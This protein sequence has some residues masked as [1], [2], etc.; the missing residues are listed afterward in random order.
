MTTTDELTQPLSAPITLDPNSLDPNSLDPNG[1]GITKTETIE[2][3]RMS[4][5]TANARWWRPLLVAVVALGIYAAMFFMMFIAM[6]VVGI[7]SPRLEAAI[8]AFLDSGNLDD[9]T[10]PV[11]FVILLGTLAMFLPAVQ[12]ATQLVGSKNAGA[13]SSVLGRLRWRWLARCLVVAMSI[14]GVALTAS[15]LVSSI[16][17]EEFAFAPDGSRVLLM[18]ALTFI[19]VPFQCAAEEY[20][21]RGYLMQTIGH[22]LRH[23][24]FAI[25][26]PVP[27]FVLGHDYQLLGQIDVAVFAIA[28]GWLTWR[29]GGLEAA[30]A[31]HIVGN[32]SGFA[33]GALGLVDV[34]STEQ[35]ALGLAFS[36]AMTVAFTVLVLRLARKHSVQRRRPVLPRSAAAI[37]TRA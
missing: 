37:A 4:R 17:G 19:L 8:D 3:H 18:L 32:V 34:N 35:S 28:A 16:Q 6:I 30:L 29:T 21:F 10:D 33:L 5:A 36:V 31:L 27:F 22:Y 1:A 26:L 9:L 23:P 20:V 25:L 13:L 2:F 12:L 24:A 15:F 7:A 14:Y 11:S